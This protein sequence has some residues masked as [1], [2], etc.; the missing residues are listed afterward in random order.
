MFV[1]GLAQVY[2]QVELST[3]LTALADN[4]NTISALDKSSMGRVRL[5]TQTVAKI[6]EYV[7]ALSKLDLSHQE[8]SLLKIIAMFSSEPVSV[9]A[10]YYEAVCDKAL[11]EL[12]ELTSKQETRY[13]RL[14]LRLSPLRS[15]QQEVLEEIF[16]GGLIGNVQIDT[17]IPILLHMKHE[18]LGQFM[19][20]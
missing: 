18:E 17:V 19:E 3:L 6:K 16:F 11:G 13:S 7:T 12:R 14:L 8:F 4:I 9:N 5:V 20:V 2:H 10:D 1:L 15:L